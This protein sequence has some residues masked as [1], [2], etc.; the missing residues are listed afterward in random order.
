MI[1]MNA[2][3]VG[4]GQKAVVDYLKVAYQHSLGGAE[5]NNEKPPLRHSD[6]DRLA[7]CNTLE[8]AYRLAT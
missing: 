4:M 3:S 6:T 5:K 8:I 1:I 7:R 2:Q